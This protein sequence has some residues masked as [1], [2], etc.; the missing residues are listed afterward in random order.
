MKLVTFFSNFVEMAAPE[1][2]QKD[3]KLI[4]L[5]HHYIYFSLGGTFGRKDSIIFSQECA[6]EFSY[7]VFP[8]NAAIFRPQ[9]DQ[10]KWLMKKM[11]ENGERSHTILY[12]RSITMAGNKRKLLNKALIVDIQVSTDLLQPGLFASD[13]ENKAYYRLL[14]IQSW[15]KSDGKLGHCPEVVAAFYQSEMEEQA[16]LS[17]RMSMGKMS[18][19]PPFIEAAAEESPDFDALQSHFCANPNFF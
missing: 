5:N 7:G 14:I 15:S 13:E 6:L 8:C 17:D 9:S 12:I 4:K 2:D 16:E 18:S 3:A 1:F 11:R 10:I 19:S